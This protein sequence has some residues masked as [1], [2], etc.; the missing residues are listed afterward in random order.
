MAKKIYVGGLADKTTEENLSK[1]FAQIGQVVSV[2]IVNKITF[3]KNSRYGYVLMKSKEE[4]DKAILT[5][6]NSL[7]DGS[8]I[9]VLEAHF[10]DQEQVRRQV[11]YRK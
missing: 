3:Q 2:K 10:L 11:R 4:V 1:H 7:L 8:K 9:K 6:N 5:L